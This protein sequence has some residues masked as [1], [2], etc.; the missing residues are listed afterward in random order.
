MLLVGV[1]AVGVGWDL[2]IMGLARHL[3]TGAA[4]DPQAA[5]EA[6]PTSP[7]GKAFVSGS[8]EGWAQA[9][10]AAGTDAAAAQAAAG[11]TTAFYTGESAPSA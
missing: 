3:E 9:S 2:A 6:W 5:L 4:Y 1:G 11:R 7:E 10:I 8:S